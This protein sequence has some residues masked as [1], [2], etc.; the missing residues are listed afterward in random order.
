MRRCRTRP[1][2]SSLSSRGSALEG[3]ELERGAGSRREASAGTAAEGAVAVVAEESGS[4]TFEGSAFVTRRRCSG[5]TWRA[6]EWLSALARDALPAVGVSV[7]EAM[8][9]TPISNTA[10]ER[11]PLSGSAC[12]APYSGGGAVQRERW[13]AEER[14]MSH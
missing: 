7:A 11:T 1:G 10:L 5:P 3:A 4:V 2:N 6:C 14:A 8:L 9:V 12:F 13:A